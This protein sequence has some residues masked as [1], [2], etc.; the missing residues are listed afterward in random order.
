MRIA[1]LTLPFHANYGGVLQAYALQTVL[2]R[3]GHEVVVLD[4]DMFHHRTWLRQQVARGAYLVRKYVLRR[5]TEYVDF[6]RMDREKRI[7][8]K[9]IRDFIETHLN[10]LRVK[11]LPHEF[12]RNVDAVVV[13]SDQV[14]RPRYFIGSY[15]CGI[16]NAYLSFLGDLPVK[17]LS[18]AAS[19]GTNEW[20]Y[21]EEETAICS[22]VLK[23]FKAVS[24][25]ENSGVSLCKEKLGCEIACQMPD[26]TFL[27]SK[28][29]Y[30]SLIED[31]EESES[32]LLYYVLDETEDIRKM[33]TSLA[34]E[35]GLAIRRLNSDLDISELPLSQRIKSP[36]EDWICGIANADYVFTDSFHACVFSILF[37]KPFKT[38]GNESR[39]MDRFRSL[40][41]VFN[42]RD[43]HHILDYH[44]KAAI[45]F[46]YNA[47]N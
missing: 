27:L 9:P 32:Y 3:M 33:A 14:W 47:L 4:K 12:P 44:R 45:S 35:K 38:V 25:R 40:F 7:V 23:H 46:L 41:A 21:S 26:P 5:Q 30:L 31:V 43:N 8:E 11:D 37:E 1:I 42:Q 17:R 22:R 28:E 39:G 16:E 36:V 13:G 15:E 19:F 20:E 10:I 29:D 2:Q 18:Y 6:R 24:V 34:R